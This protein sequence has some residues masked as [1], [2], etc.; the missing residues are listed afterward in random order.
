MLLTKPV[1][2]LSEFVRLRRENT[3]LR[4]RLSQL[5]AVSIRIS[6]SLDSKSVLQEVVDSARTLAAAQ[7]GVMIT[8]AESGE[9]EEVVTSGMTPHQASLMPETPRGLGLLGYLKELRWPLRLQDISSHPRSVGFPKNHPPMRTFLGMPVYH[10]GTHIGN[11]F[12]TEKE[13]GQEFS[14]EDEEIVTM[15]A[16]QAAIALSNARRYEKERMA[17]ADLEAMVNISPV[18]VLVIDAVTTEVT[19]INAEALRIVGDLAARDTPTKE[20][21]LEEFAGQ[22]AFRRADGTEIPLGSDPMARALQSG[23]TVRAEEIVISRADGRSVSTLINAAPISSDEGHIKSVV[24]ALQDLAPLEELER[25]RSEFLGLVSH[26]LRT[27]LSTIKGSAS[28]LLSIVDGMNQTEPLQLLRIIDQQADLMRSQINSLIELTHIEAGTLP[29]SLEAVNVAELIDEASKEF[30]R[31]NLSTF[32]RVIP[33]SLPKVMADRQRI[34][35]VLKNLIHNV[36]NHS[37]EDSPIEVAATQD[38]L[39]VVISV[40]AEA[41]GMISTEPA[42]LFRK[43]LKSVFDSERGCRGDGH[44]LGP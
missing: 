8:Y 25:L 11:I 2:E 41:G 40:S 20:M 28:A 7:Y 12:L 6:E 3:A 15:I 16:S 13:E 26:E 36:S 31:G 27:P 5:S 35:Q 29:V 39:Y 30:W 18:G 17:K 22:V 9:V 4:D 38:D 42:Q 24:V 21:T 34:A 1:E 10:Q 19:A 43:C 44:K 32:T 23:E 33:E 37:P 14:R